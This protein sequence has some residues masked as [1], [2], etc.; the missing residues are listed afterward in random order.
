MVISPYDHP[1]FTGEETKANKVT[2]LPRSQVGRKVAFPPESGS[3]PVEYTTVLNVLS[4][5]T[6]EDPEERTG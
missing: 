5:W 1:K 4:Q 3:E 2:N 6:Q